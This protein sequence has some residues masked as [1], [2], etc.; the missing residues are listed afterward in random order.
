M[1][2]KCLIDTQ[3]VHMALQSLEDEKLNYKLFTDIKVEPSDE[4]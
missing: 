1:T 4:R 3:G 2:D